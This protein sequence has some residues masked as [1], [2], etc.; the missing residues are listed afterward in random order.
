MEQVREIFLSVK[1][2]RQYTKDQILQDYLNTIYFGRGAWGIQS[3][4]QTYFG[5]DVD[6]LT[7][8][9]GA[10]L[11]QVIRP[12]VLRPETDP[13][14]AEARFR[15]VLDGMAQQGWLGDTDPA[16]VPFPAAAPRP[17]PRAPASAAKPVT[18]GRLPAA[19]SWR[20]AP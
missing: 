11:A 6:Q 18:C 8:D 12:H 4:A 3:A 5:V 7:V 2:D 1:L 9:Q 15:Y 10:V 13:Q 19:T 20:R 17:S 16:T 14:R